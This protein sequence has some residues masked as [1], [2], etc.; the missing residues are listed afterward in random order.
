MESVWFRFLIQLYESTHSRPSQHWGCFLSPLE[1]KWKNYSEN[2]RSVPTQSIEVNIVSTGIAQEGQVFFE[3]DDVELPSEE[4]LLKKRQEKFTAVNTEPP[5]LYIFMLLHNQDADPV[6]LGFKRK[7]LG[8]PLVLSNLGNKSRIISLLANKKRIII[9][10]NI[11][12]RQNYNEVGG[13][14]LYKCYYQ[15]N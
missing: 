8:K 13:M 7:L 2:W 9:G 15:C 3:T 11:L 12:F 10:D 1:P 5:V 6:L 14:G 4:Q